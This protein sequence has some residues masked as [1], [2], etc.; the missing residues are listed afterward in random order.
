MLRRL[1]DHVQH[2]P[3]RP[4]YLADRLLTSW[5]PAKKS[6]NPNAHVSGN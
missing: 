6:W 5:S 1:L 3:N 2:N 4:S